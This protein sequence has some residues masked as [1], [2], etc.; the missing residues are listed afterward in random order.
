MA[1][2]K[3]FNSKCLLILINLSFNLIK[4]MCEDG[5]KNLS[6]RW[7]Q[8]WQFSSTFN[9]PLERIRKVRYLVNNIPVNAYLSSEA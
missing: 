9:K 7:I 8:R 6:K 1:G 3:T 4:F 2:F 5:R